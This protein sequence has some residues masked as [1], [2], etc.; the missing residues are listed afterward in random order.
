MAVGA[1]R[2]LL[3]AATT[4]ERGAGGA[5]RGRAALVILLQ[6]SPV[7]TPHGDRR[8]HGRA[9]FLECTLRN[10]PRRSPEESSGRAQATYA[11]RLS[12]IP[13]TGPFE[14]K[15][16]PVDRREQQA[17]F[18]IE[19]QAD[20]D[21]VNVSVEG[22]IWL[23]WYVPPDRLH[24]SVARYR[25]GKIAKEQEGQSKLFVGQGYVTSRESNG[26]LPRVEQVR[27]PNFNVPP[28]GRG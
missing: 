4:S 2:P 28:L 27:S 3:P 11:A 17:I 8:G 10:A 14:P 13:R 22:T 25:L 1:T 5:C 9:E 21:P 18:G 16:K 19:S 6:P 26:P 23:V 15:A 24:D 7:T 20:S 12:S